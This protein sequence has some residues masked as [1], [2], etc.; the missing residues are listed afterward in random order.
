MSNGLNLELDKYLDRK[1]QQPQKKEDR[2]KKKVRHIPLVGE[3]YEVM[4]KVKER[5]EIVDIHDDSV[6]VVEQRPFWGTFK[7]AFSDVFLVKK[8]EDVDVPVESVNKSLEEGHNVREEIKPVK[9]EDFFKHN[10]SPK[11]DEGVIEVEEEP[12]NI[13]DNV[14]DNMNR[15]DRHL[16]KTFT[17]KELENELIP[18]SKEPEEKISY[19]KVVLYKPQAKDEIKHVLQVTHDLI[20]LV[21]KPA[22]E[23]FKDSE[24]FQKYEHLLEKYG[25]IDKKE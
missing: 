9:N 4:K 13:I 1:N 18:E 2:W 21:P 19:N 16:N 22:L 3:L 12:D 20:K 15:K 6:H 24:D 14:A 23:E 7:K 8:T 10:F 5:E 25:I 17:E 11:K